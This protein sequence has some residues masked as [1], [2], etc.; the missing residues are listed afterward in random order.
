MKVTEHKTEAVHGRVWPHSK[1]GI[2]GPHDIHL[3]IRSQPPIVREWP[4]KYPVLVHLDQ[5]NNLDNFTMI[6]VLFMKPGTRTPSLV[7]GLRF[8]RIKQYR[9]KGDEL[10]IRIRTRLTRTLPHPMP[11]GQYTGTVIYDDAGKFAVLTLQASTLKKEPEPSTPKT[12]ITPG[13]AEYHDTLAD[14]KRTL[15]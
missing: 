12:I 6:R 5:P 9:R 13:D 4:D 2:H 15:H 7:A 1:K 8:H 14:A 3:G 10:K 11:V